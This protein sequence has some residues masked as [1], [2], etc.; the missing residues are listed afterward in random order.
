[1][2]FIDDAQIDKYG[3]L[4]QQQIGCL[5]ADC[6]AAEPFL[7]EWTKLMSQCAEKPNSTAEG[8]WRLMR[9]NSSRLGGG[10]IVVLD[11]NTYHP[12]AY[13]H[14]VILDHALIE[15]FRLNDPLL[16]DCAQPGELLLTFA[17]L[18][19]AYRGARIAEGKLLLSPPGGWDELEDKPGV[20]FYYELYRR[21][22]IQWGNG[23]RIWNRTHPDCTRVIATAAKFGLKPTGTIEVLQGGKETT[24]VVLCTEGKFSP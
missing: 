9:E 15:T 12:I 5:L 19:E 24:K 21:R 17:G 13:A 20:G 22:L 6:M 18:A 10:S 7:M 2:L 11:S 4:L 1:M 16:Q 23:L 3:V 8:T 14:C